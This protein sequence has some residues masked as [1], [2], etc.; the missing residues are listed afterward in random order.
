VVEQKA[1]QRQVGADLPARDDQWCGAG[2]VG[3]VDRAE[4]G[5]ESHG[6][7]RERGNYETVRQQKGIIR[8]SDQ[9]HIDVFANLPITPISKGATNENT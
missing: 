3:D 6:R 5:S 4:T 1:D 2:R 8:F 9:F 7:Q